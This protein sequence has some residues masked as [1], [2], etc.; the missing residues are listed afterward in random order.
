MVVTAVGKARKF[1]CHRYYKK[2]LVLETNLAL[3]RVMEMEERGG[4][5]RK[6]K[7]G[8]GKGGNT[9]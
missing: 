1:L 5:E 6:G 8:E 4:K 3:I 9:Y 7:E 2:I